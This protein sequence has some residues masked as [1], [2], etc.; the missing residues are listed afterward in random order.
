MILSES[1]TLK[2]EITIRDIWK[3]KKRIAPLVNKT[4]LLHS[5]LLSKQNKSSVFFKLE[6]LHQTGSFKLRGA[7][8][9]ILSLSSEEKQNGVTT[10][11]TGNHGMSVAYVAKQIGI[12][13][14]VCISNRVPDVKV[15]RIKDLGAEIVKV[16][17]NQDDAENYC[18]DLQKKRGMTVIKPF[19]D[20]YIIAG[21][22]TIGLE[23]LE[24]MPNIDTVV[25]PLSGGGLLSGIGL[26][27]KS[28]DPSIKVIG[29]SME[30]SAVMYE[31]LKANRP[32]ILK[33]Q[34]TLADSLLGGIGL[35]NQYTF[36]MVK[37]YMD[38]V[39][40]LSEEEIAE[41]MAFMLKNYQ[42]GIEGASATGIASVLKSKFVSKDKN[43]AI[44][45]TGCNVDMSRLLEVS[46][47][48]LNN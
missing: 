44:I 22:G 2:N 45:I 10:F 4:N 39:L 19:D 1:K 31:S 40:L 21:Q 16:G 20:P 35:D 12:P 7:A 41:G 43:I 42:M 8:N 15:Q 23:L 47:K 17:E 34:P 9:K 28:I 38:D 14:T 37:Q 6:N 36:D 26:A 48:Y 18:Y 29:V 30:R 33:E 24:D 27:L 13:A 5:A 32:V 11:S 25:V 46:N 3:A